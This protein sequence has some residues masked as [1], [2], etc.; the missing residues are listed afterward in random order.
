M[1]NYEAVAMI[2]LG[3][4]Y[5]ASSIYLEQSKKKTINNFKDWTNNYFLP[6]SKE[7]LAKMDDFK[8]KL[9]KLAKN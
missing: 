3:L 7:I 8:S 1:T 5:V 9:E 4:T 2:G 6:K